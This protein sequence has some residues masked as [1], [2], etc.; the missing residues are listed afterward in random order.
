VGG[1]NAAIPSRCAPASPP[2]PISQ[3]LR[4]W[5]ALAIAV[6]LAPSPH[7]RPLSIEGRGDVA[8]RL[9][10]TDLVERVEGHCGRPRPSECSVGKESTRLPG[11][12]RT[13][14]GAGT[15]CLL[16][17]AGRPDAREPFSRLREGA[18]ALGPLRPQACGESFCSVSTMAIRPLMNWSRCRSGRASRMRSST[19]LASGSAVRSA[20]RPSSVSFTA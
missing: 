6:S 7:P 4:S 18:F 5:R 9:S 3:R 10:R 13:S 20:L 17:L 15:R 12:T 19:R 16:A 1:A 8:A 2:R 11:G 14:Q